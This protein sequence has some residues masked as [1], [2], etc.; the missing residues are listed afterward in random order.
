MEILKA[1]YSMELLSVVRNYGFVRPLPLRQRKLIEFFKM[2]CPRKLGK[3]N[4]SF[5]Y[6]E[7]ERRD[8]KRI[9]VVIQRACMILAGKVHLIEEFMSFFV[10]EFMEM[11]RQF[12]TVET[13]HFDLK[14]F[15]LM[16]E[17]Y[18]VENVDHEFVQK[19]F[20]L[21]R[22]QGLVRNDPF[23]IEIYEALDNRHVRLRYFVNTS[24]VMLCVLHRE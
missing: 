17:T 14:P 19:H 4:I 22:R 2:F 21:S 7:M 20:K 5:H 12:D 18:K 10:K 23:E 15:R 9:S 24:N 8:N 1:N 6:G 11:K 16:N 3:E 13:S